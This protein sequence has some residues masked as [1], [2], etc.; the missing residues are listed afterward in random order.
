M[1]P[2]RS[3]TALLILTAFFVCPAGPQ[4]KNPLSIATRSETPVSIQRLR[5]PVTFDGLSEEDAWR[6]I[7][8]LPMVMMTP[9]FGFPPSEKTELKVGFDDEYLW[10]AGRLYDREPARIQ[11][12]S[13]KRDLQ[14]ASSD[15]FAVIIDTFNDKENALAFAT[16]P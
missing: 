13:K 6:N 5:S 7:Q 12:R 16:T 4:E 15:F 8:V 9:N 1:R 2:V 3:V 14:E 11:A 10:V